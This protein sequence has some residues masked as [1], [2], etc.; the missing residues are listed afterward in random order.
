MDIIYHQLGSLFNSLGPDVVCIIL[1]TGIWAAVTAVYVPGM[2]VPEGSAILCLVVGGIG[3]IFLPSN[4][5]GVLLLVVALSCFLAQ[6]F[7]RRQWLLTAIG[8]VF[9]VLGSIFLFRLGAR[10]SVGVIVIGNA[11]ALAFHEL[12]LRPGL[13]AQHTI[14]KMDMDT[15][16]GEIGEV[17]APLNP[18]GT[19][20]VRSELWSAISESHIEAGQQVR[21]IGRDGLRLLVEPLDAMGT[22][23]RV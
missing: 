8:M 11:S 2:A 14:S 12:I 5:L 17:V 15:L 18:R 1:L 4:V 21:V 3:L 13:R 7:F 23:D 22:S 10:P 6:I 16:L 9:Q 20:R 19:I